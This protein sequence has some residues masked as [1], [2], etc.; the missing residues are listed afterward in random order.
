MEKFCENCDNIL[1]P[2]EDDDKLILQ[3][4]NC[5]HKEDNKDSLIVEKIYKKSADASHTNVKYVVYDNTLRRTTK[6]K[7]PNNKCKS[8]DKKDL[9]ESVIVIDKVTK[10]KIYICINCFTQWKQ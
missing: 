5:G 7:C 10:R 3:C 2:E 1:Y 6:V 4:K 8:H 9:Q